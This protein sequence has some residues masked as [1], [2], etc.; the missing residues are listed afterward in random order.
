MPDRLFEY[1][2]VNLK[3]MLPDNAETATH[4]HTIIKELYRE[5]EYEAL[6]VKGRVVLDIGAY[7]GETAI[8]FER[9][10][11]ERIIAIEPMAT[12]DYIARNAEIN[13]AGA[14]IL[15]VRGYVG[16][17]L[18]GVD[19]SFANNGASRI[20]EGE[21]SVRRYTL[22]ELIAEFA[23]P[24]GSVLKI[25]VEGSEYRFFAEAGDDD[26][27]QFSQIAAEIHW[28]PGHDKDM[29]ANRLIAAGFEV[30]SRREYSGTWILQARLKA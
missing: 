28:D 14:K 3:V 18:H 30:T 9:K 11:A 2:E 6:D 19:I 12:F 4:L 21:A 17:E 24:K 13:N 15:P 25:D 27:R 26:F 5:G 1:P 22:K 8:Y 16:P 7:L 20:R 10:G 29:P 23:I